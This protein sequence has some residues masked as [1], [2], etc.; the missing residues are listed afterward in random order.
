MT[1]VSPIFE[2]CT[3]HGLYNASCVM[4]PVN[5]MPKKVIMPTKRF[6]QLEKKLEPYKDQPDM[7]SFVGM[8]EPLLDKE[9]EIKI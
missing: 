3:V 8:G 6:L 7:I 1:F 4:C 5:E 2:I 9:V